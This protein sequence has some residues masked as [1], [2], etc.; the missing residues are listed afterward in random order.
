MDET[1]FFIC[2]AIAWALRQYSY[3]VPKDIIQFM[4]EYRNDLSPLSTSEA[5]KALNRNGYIQIEAVKNNQTSI[6]LSAL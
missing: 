4:K 5:L 3:T 2:K 6:Y 1:E